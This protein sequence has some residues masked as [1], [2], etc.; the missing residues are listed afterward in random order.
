MYVHTY[1]LESVGSKTSEKIDLYE[2]K[3]RTPGNR[4]TS[5]SG[6]LT[7]SASSDND[8]STPESRRDQSM[9]GLQEERYQG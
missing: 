2:R 1:F 5:F 7:L 6:L 4:P 9:A 3:L 8:H